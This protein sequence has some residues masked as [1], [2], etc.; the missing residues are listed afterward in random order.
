M[1]LLN[2]N[3]LGKLIG[4]TL[5]SYLGVKLKITELPS[6]VT[7]RQIL[8]ITAI[9]GVGFTMAIFI[10]NLAF[11]GEDANVNSAKVGII[12]RVLISGFVGVFYSTSGK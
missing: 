6:G 7:F 5:F 9:A 11:N 1:K 8:G 10:D 3:F 12:I 4:G 2:G